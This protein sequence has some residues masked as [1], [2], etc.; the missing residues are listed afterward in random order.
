MR[1][2]RNP[3][4]WNGVMLAAVHASVR[5]R[6]VMLA[7]VMLA[8]PTA[9]AHAQLR[10]RPTVLRTDGD[11]LPA[12]RLSFEHR[13]AGLDAVGS[14][15]REWTWAAIAD[16]PIVWNASRNPE[17]LRGALSAGL[18]IS[19]YKPPPPPPETGPT[20]DDPGAAWNYGYVAFELLAAVEAPQDVEFADI[21]LGGVIVY[22]HDQYTRLWFVPE[23]RASFGTVL[24]ASCDDT[25]SAGVDAATDD[26]HLR[27]DA[28]LGWNIPMDRAWV[29]GPLKPVWLRL[30]GR[31][32]QP[33][34]LNE[35]FLED[36]PRSEGGRW[37][38]AEVA[39]RVDD[40]AWLHEVFVRWHGG[41][42]PVQLRERHA[43]RVGVSLFL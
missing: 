40:I 21:T 7:A 4:L 6:V 10:L 36:T 11:V 28:E 20:I 31:M 35:E 19:L 5:R 30:R 8:A 42:L 16:A 33:W 15:P 24:C 13:S 38:S 34:G 39:Y 1:A 29:P 23:L 32:F 3:A 17:S 27:I 22:E 9:G 43:W 37:G 41:E 25:D 12:L 18:Q 2:P 26:Q 14:F